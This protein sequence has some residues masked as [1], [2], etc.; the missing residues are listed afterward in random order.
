[1]QR[2]CVLGTSTCTT[3]RRI[4][5]RSMCF[6]YGLRTLLLVVALVAILLGCGSHLYSIY[7]LESRRQHTLKRLGGHGGSDRDRVVMAVCKH[8]LVRL[9]KSQHSWM[10]LRRNIPTW[11]TSSSLPGFPTHRSPMGCRSRSPMARP[12]TSNYGARGYRKT[13]RLPEEA[14]SIKAVSTVTNSQP[15]RIKQP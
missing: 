7:E 2:V 6:R 10:S 9:C 15:R 11:A 13:N 4:R 8:Q 12:P 1:M 5:G 3:I 14:S